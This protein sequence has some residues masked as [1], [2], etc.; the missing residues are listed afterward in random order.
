[1]LV[2]ALEIGLA[3]LHRVLVVSGQ[4]GVQVVLLVEHARALELSEGHGVRDHLSVY[5]CVC[6]CVCVCVWG[7]N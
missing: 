6:V 1:M 4:V 5:L 7:G 2:L 3:H